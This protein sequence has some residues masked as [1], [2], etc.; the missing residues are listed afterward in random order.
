ME[1]I[2]DLIIRNIPNVVM[3]RERL[4][5]RLNDRAVEEGLSEIMLCHVIGGERG[6]PG[7][8]FV[9]FRDIS[10]NEQAL[11]WN[12]MVF[13]KHR[14]VF[15]ANRRCLVSW[16]RVEWELAGELRRREDRAAPPPQQRV[17]TVERVD[18]WEDADFGEAPGPHEER[19]NEEQGVAA[20]GD[21]GE[22]GGS[23]AIP[24]ELC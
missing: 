3:S 13:Y 14:L 5:E 11:G 7:R 15:E 23:V 10:D 4:L 8:A 16:D 19:G 9:S 20:T 21:G 2:F 18:S 17:G 12:E 24:T 1:L 22:T 6:E